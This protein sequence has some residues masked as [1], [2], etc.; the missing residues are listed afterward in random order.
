MN[1]T[2]ITMQKKNAGSDPDGATVTNDLNR[3]ELGLEAPD[4]SI[5]ADPISMDEVCEAGNL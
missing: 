2:R 5:L 4:L 3:E 1:E